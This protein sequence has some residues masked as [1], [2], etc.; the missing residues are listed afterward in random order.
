MPVTV[1]IIH[2]GIS[3]SEKS[4]CG[5]KEN[6]PVLGQYFLKNFCHM[7]EVEFED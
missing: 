4:K 6:F 7:K 5:F 2:K 1:L 3:L